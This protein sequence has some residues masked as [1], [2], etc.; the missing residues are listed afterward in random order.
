MCFFHN[1]QIFIITKKF[2]HCPSNLNFTLFVGIKISLIFNRI[3]NIDHMIWHWEIYSFQCNVN[4]RVNK[5]W[6]CGFLILKCVC[7]LGT[8]VA[9]TFDNVWKASDFKMPYLMTYFEIT[10]RH[11][12]QQLLLC[13]IIPYYEIC[14]L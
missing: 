8:T 9:S 3:A 5:I 7:Q 10:F 13:I 11:K 1:G 6:I 4:L 12:G 2:N 14:L